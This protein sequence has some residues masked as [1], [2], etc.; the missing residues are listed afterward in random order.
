MLTVKTE[1]V[2][3]YVHSGKHSHEQR[4]RGISA[5]IVWSRL[6]LAN[7]RPDR[8]EGHCS[9]G[10]LDFGL[11]IERGL[12]GAVGTCAAADSLS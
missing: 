2:L 1:Y 3:F 10:A 7:L 4:V 5:I 12:S 6:V 11:L 8:Q 9:H